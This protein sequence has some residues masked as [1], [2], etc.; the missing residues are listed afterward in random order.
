MYFQGRVRQGVPRITVPF[1][2]AFNDGSTPHTVIM[3]SRQEQALL[4]VEEITAQT[5]AV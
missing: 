2:T 3:S 5:T 1:L 4:G